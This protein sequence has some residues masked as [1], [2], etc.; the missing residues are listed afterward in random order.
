MLSYSGPSRR[1]GLGRESRGSLANGCQIAGR[2]YL[3]IPLVKPSSPTLFPPEL[4]F[5]YLIYALGL[6]F[7]LNRWF[8][9][10]KKKKDINFEKSLVQVDITRVWKGKYYPPKVQLNWGETGREKCLFDGTWIREKILTQ[11]SD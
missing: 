5:L 6:R 3:R 10:K 2:R 8:R 11:Q 7:R 1:S 4:F 9:W